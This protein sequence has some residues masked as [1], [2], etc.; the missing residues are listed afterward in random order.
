[1]GC[2]SGVWH[3]VRRWVGMNILL[4]QRHTF[5]YDCM[6]HE[7]YDI[8]SIALYR[9]I[10]IDVQIY[11]KIKNSLH[12]IIRLICCSSISAQLQ[13]DSICK[14]SQ[15]NHFPKSSVTNRP[16]LTINTRCALLVSL[17]ISTRK[18]YSECPQV[19]SRRDLTRQ[20]PPDTYDQ[21]SFCLFLQPILC[22]QERFDFVMCGGIYAAWSECKRTEIGESGVLR[23]REQRGFCAA[24]DDAEARGVEGGC[25]SSTFARDVHEVYWFGG[26][27]CGQRASEGE[28]VGYGYPFVFTEKMNISFTFSFWQNS[29][30]EQIKLNSEI[31]RG[32]H[33]LSTLLT[34]IPCAHTTPFTSFNPS[35]TSEP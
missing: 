10:D 13:P 12:G 2:L 34:L 24:F 14:S 11:F 22:R 32:S 3:W 6:K 17:S 27:C 33:S 25:G 28:W 7:L 4:S 23:E 9:I 35:I 19:P 15:T 18:F 16:P 20:Q 1:M 29:E 8:I 31:E 30:F 21:Q 5:L 26:G